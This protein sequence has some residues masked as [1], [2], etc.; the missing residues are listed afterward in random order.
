MAVVIALAL[1]SSVAGGQAGGRGTIKGHVK[2]TGKLP[3]NPVIR[4]GMDPMCAKANAGKQVVQETVMAALDGSLANVFVSLEGTFPPTPVSSEPV[5]IDQRACVYRPRVVGARVGQTLQVRNSDDLIHNVH[6]LTE[7][8]NAFNI[9]EPKAGMVQSFKLKDAEILR[10]KCD[11]HRW[12]TTYV[13][14]VGNP[15]FAVSNDGGNFEIANVPPGSYTIRAWHELYGP[16]TQRV[17]VRA[18]A[19]ATINFSYTGKEGASTK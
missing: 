9:S 17:A 6:S 5:V 10:I 13:G 4:M 11:V 3:G 2:L 15:Y 16:V 7:K 12:M 14:I 1:G 18:G 8:G 19:T